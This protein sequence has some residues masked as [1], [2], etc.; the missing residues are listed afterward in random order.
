MSPL[1]LSA[2]ISCGF[3]HRVRRRSFPLWLFLRVVLY[4]RQICRKRTCSEGVSYN[5][6][7]SSANVVKTRL[8]HDST[9]AGVALVSS[10]RVDLPLRQA[11]SLK[12]AFPIDEVA[13][14]TRPGV[15]LRA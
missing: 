13:I 15:R 11:D 9:K 7:V 6:S 14:A 12:W 8:T 4:E 10:L 1:S 2:M 5:S 3:S